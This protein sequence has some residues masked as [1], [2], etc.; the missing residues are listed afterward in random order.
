MIQILF[1]VPYP[2][3]EEK[4]KFVLQSHPERQRMQVDIVVRSVDDPLPENIAKY[5][6]I[7]ARGYTA[8]RTKAQYP[9]IPTI[10]LAISGYD[11]I[12]AVLECQRKYHPEKTAVCGFYGKLYEA[13]HICRSLGVNVGVFTPDSPEEV[14]QIVTNLKKWGY[15]ALIGGYTAM[16]HAQQ[17]GIPAV[18]IRTGEDTVLQTVNDTLRTVDS[19]R[20]EKLR[21][22][23]YKT[24]IYAAQ[25]GVLFVNAAGN[26]QVRNQVAKRMVG[27]FSLQNKPFSQIFPELF[28]DYRKVFA[29][30]KA[31]EGRIYTLP[32]TK[33]VV[34]V[35]MDPVIVGSQ[36]QGVVVTLSD[37][38]KIQE[39][40]GHIRRKLNEK[41]HR[42]KYTFQ[43]II[44][45]SE[46]ISQTIEVARKYAAFDSNIILVGETGTGK[47][48]FAQS[49]HNASS[50]KNGPFV[51]INCA[52]LPENLL[53]SE[54]F[55]YVEGAF[56]GTVKGGKMGLFEQAHGG[57]LFLDEIG[58]ISMPI[59]TKLLRV[60]QER[61][62]RR[63]GDN[64]VIS[65]NVRIIS[66]T[67]KSILKMAQEGTFRRDLVYRLD[68]LRIFLPPLRKREGDAQLLFQF[69]LEEICAKQGFREAKMLPDCV[70]LL[71]EYPFSGNIRELRNIAERAAVLGNGVVDREVLALALY[72]EDLEMNQ[73]DFLKPPKAP[74]LGEPER[75]RQ[76][77]D[78]AGWNQSQA[79]RMLGIDRSTLWRKL[80][81]YGIE[82]PGK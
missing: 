32:A 60:L 71:L 78:E 17:A 38:T 74:V 8:V 31:L 80:R 68:V 55:G 62:V 45:S 66:A 2:E 12:N 48:L 46:A 20:Q 50:R 14:C 47:E 21:A 10:D 54:L 67:N 27:N 25:D 6:A 42:A 52:A 70:P 39:L 33:T 37:I 75:L 7:V 57:T 59:Q 40:E 4:V 72:P 49:I 9:Q 23:M 18:V 26:I 65:V 30:G 63:I 29:T 15:D 79:A 41:G 1:I 24:I 28:K 35:Q 69:Y 76:A 13:E 34:S 58:E 82:V 73:E 64:K 81:K 19:V 11:I 5:D 77:L 61:E 3:L 43:D 53:E 56:T 16:Q 22:E 44:H 51:A 36:V